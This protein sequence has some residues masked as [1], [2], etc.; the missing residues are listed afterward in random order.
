MTPIDDPDDRAPTPDGPG[1]NRPV[2]AQVTCRPW[3]GAR[4]PDP[5]RR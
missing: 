1:P 4:R 2:S 5:P 3:L